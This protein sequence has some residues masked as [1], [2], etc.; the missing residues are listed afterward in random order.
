[1]KITNTAKNYYRSNI[2]PYG[3]TTGLATGTVRMRN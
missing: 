3:S 1:M 2:I